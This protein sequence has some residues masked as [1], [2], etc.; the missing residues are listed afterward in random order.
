MA[1][2]NGNVVA[3]TCFSGGLFLLSI[4]CFVLF[5]G[6]KLAEIGVVASWSWWWVTA[7]LWIYFSFVILVAMF[8]IFIVVAAAIFCKD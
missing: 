6:L 2:N 1:N 7:P 5:L 4:L 8:I 3:N